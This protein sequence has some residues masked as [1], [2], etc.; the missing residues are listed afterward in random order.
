MFYSNNQLFL[1]YF[2]G[3]HYQA[4]TTDENGEDVASGRYQD[5]AEQP[6]CRDCI[7]GK[8][9]PESGSP[10]CTT[11][12]LGKYQNEKGKANCKEC[13]SGL[14]NAPNTKPGNEL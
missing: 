8:E 10:V 13:E 11:C 14:F 9:S 2:L 12:L 6:K 4:K 1:F 3:C 5:L 7:Q